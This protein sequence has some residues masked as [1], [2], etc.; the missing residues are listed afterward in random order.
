MDELGIE[1][2][3]LVGLSMGGQII[4]EF[5]RLFSNRVKSL[6]ICTSTPDSET[7]ISYQNRM[8]LIDEISVIG[9]LEY[10]KR[11]IHKYINID[12]NKEGSEVYNH[13][14]EMM[15]GT[16]LQGVVASHRGRAE[17]RN[18]FA[19]LK[20]IDKPTLVIAT[21][22]DYFYKAESVKEVANQISNSIFK[23]IDKSGHLPNMEKPEIFNKY[24]SQFYKEIREV[25]K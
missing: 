9:M 1:K 3:H 23:F 6:V 25:N 24:L 19:Y 15:A 11:D 5:C 7:E 2:V 18:N 22:K 4:I 17:R 16:P 21:E 14:F 8:K 13:L 12:D 20:L 10:T